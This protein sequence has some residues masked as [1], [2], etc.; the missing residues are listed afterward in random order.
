MAAVSGPGGMVHYFDVNGQELGSN[1]IQQSLTDKSVTTISW[2]APAGTLIS[3]I[4]IDVGSENGGGTMRLD[5]FSWGD[6]TQSVA[7][8]VANSGT[9][10]A[11]PD[12]ALMALATDA[13]AVHLDLNAS[14][15]TANTHEAATQQGHLSLSLDDVLS[16]GGESAF[17]ADGK[18]QFA[19]TGEAGEHV[20]LTGVSD[21]SLAHAGSVTSGGMTYDVYSVSGS[22]AELLVQHGLE[23]H[24]T[25]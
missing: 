23:L 10:V 25:A 6:E 20:E 7:Q 4:T 12:V 11:H 1:E 18:T 15:T 14:H 16:Q 17:I 3:Y 21:S 9:E 24:T 2:E 8:S 22:N 5:N 19:V 13:Q